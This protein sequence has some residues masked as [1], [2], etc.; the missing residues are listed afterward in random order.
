M[1]NWLKETGWTPGFNDPTLMGWVTTIS[2]MLASVLSFCLSRRSKTKGFRFFHFWRILSTTLLLLGLNK[3]LDLQ[4]I[5]VRTASRL[6]LEN[7]WYQQRY[8]A[9]YGFV[10]I[11]IAAALICGAWLIAHKGDYLPADPFLWAGIGLVVSFVLI[12]TAGLKIG[13]ITNNYGTDSDGLV[14]FLELGAALWLNGAL[15][16]AIRIEDIK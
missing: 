3:Q 14:H 5:L 2:Y 6:A 13:L 7:G 16:R 4:I 11:V 10:A 15:A 8:M 1:M 12:R 9:R